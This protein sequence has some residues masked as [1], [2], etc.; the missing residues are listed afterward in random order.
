MAKCRLCDHLNPAGVDRCQ[1]CGTW[2]D[3]RDTEP[4][5]APPTSDQGVEQPAP[6]PNSLEGRV[7][8][9][10]QAGRKIEAVKLYRAERNVGLKEA[11][12]AVEDLA[13][14]H[15]IAATRGGCAG[16]LLLLVTVG[17]LIATL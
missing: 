3:D 11:K 8:A 15:G 10:L 12:D 4:N 1:K 7:L 13:Q 9:A 6:A 16:V 14:E 17:V 2:I 5:A